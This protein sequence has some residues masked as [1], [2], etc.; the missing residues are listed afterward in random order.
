MRWP[1]DFVLIPVGANGQPALAVYLRGRDGRYLAHAIQ[2]LTPTG[3]GLARIV[4]FNEP[5]L[6]AMFGLAAVRLAG[7][8]RAARTVRHKKADDRRR[9]VRAGGRRTG[10]AARRRAVRAGQDGQMDIRPHRIEIPQADL[11]DLRDRLARTRWPDQL[12]GTGWDY[13]IPLEWCGSWPSTGAPGT[14]GGRPSARLNGFGQF[15]TVIDGQRMHFLHVRSAEP[16]ALPLIMTHG[17]PGSIV[18]FTERHRPADR[19]GGAR[20]RSGRRVPPGRPVHPRLRV[21]R[22]DPGPGLERAPDRAGLGVADASASATSGT[23]PRAATGARRSPGSS[24]SSLP[25]TSSACT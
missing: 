12:P 18:E 23:A 5:W 22:A 10:E 2:V 8:R 9:A 4:S 24:A 1:G 7:G 11:D 20:R 21:L 3:A 13:G 16:G 6:F 19:P 17:W 14:T 25:G 15:T